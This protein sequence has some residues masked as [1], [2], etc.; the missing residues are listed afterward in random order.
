MA[1][2]SVVAVLETPDGTEKIRLDLDPRFERSLSEILHAV[3]CA[4]SA[5][6]PG[7]TLERHIAWRVVT[8]R[9]IAPQ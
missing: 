7:R 4:S 1:D 8:G 6:R 9:Q 3:A 2:T 5:V